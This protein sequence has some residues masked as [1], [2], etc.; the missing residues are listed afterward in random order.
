MKTL[1]K[2]AFCLAGLVA[3]SSAVG[4][5]APGS[6]VQ[7]TAVSSGVRDFPAPLFFQKA[8]VALP[9]NIEIFDAWGNLN[10]K[11][12]YIEN[13]RQWQRKFIRDN[14]LG[15]SPASRSLPDGTLMDFA[16]QLANPDGR[17]L[18]RTDMLMNRTAVGN[19]QL[20]RMNVRM[21]SIRYVD[22]IGAGRLGVTQF[23]APQKVGYMRTEFR[24][25]RGGRK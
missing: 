15:D 10:K 12:E 7:D 5:E 4:Q 14:H 6:P 3:L 23:T 17:D 8:A 25:G 24:I 1:Y 2:V 9:D 11:P 19:T 13:L 18:Y 20:E 16:A 21:R 22:F